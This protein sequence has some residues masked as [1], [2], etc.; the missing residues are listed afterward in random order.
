MYKTT[1][2]KVRIYKFIPSSL[3]TETTPLASL[4]IEMSSFFLQIESY[5]DY[6]VNYSMG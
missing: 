6:D 4:L 3:K 5:S 1:E 2:G